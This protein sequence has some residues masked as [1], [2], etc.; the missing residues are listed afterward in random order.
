M[1]LARL[2]LTGLV[3]AGLAAPTSLRAQ[4]P[5]PAPPPRS[6]MP[7][8][9]PDATMSDEARRIHDATEDLAELTATPESGIPRNLLERAE[10]IIVIPSLVKGGFIVGGKHGKGIVSI[11][12]RS[13]NS[14]SAPAF[15][16]MTGGSVGWQIGVESVDLVL[17][18][19]NKD[20]MKNLLQDK[21]TIGAEGSATVGPVGRTGK[22]AT[23]AQLQAQILSWSRSQGA[24][25]GAALDGSVVKP[26][27]SRNEAVYG[28][29]T[30]AKSILLDHKMPP[31]ADAAA[32]LKVLNENAARG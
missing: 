32:F 18:V 8:D 20:G 4:D 2:F 30:T 23:D 31:P 15:I 19:M 16:N 11:R 25:L 10:A 26:D 13:T 9:H 3:V 6:T 21:F 5:S 28:K 24:F 29:G 14:W 17:L 27:D 12:D 1:A 7:V 22:A